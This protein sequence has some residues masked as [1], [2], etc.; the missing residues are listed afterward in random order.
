MIIQG[1][2]RLDNNTLRFYASFV[3]IRHP[4]EA[5]EALNPQYRFLEGGCEL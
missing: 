1:D 2:L 5:L 3:I 4:K